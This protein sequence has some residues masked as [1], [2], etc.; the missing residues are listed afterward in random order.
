VSEDV[1]VAALV[2]PAV[3]ES[4]ARRV[5]AAGETAMKLAEAVAVLGETTLTDAGKLAE[6]AETEVVAAADRLA[7]VDILARGALLTFVHPVVRE[8]ARGQMSPARLAM[9]HTRAAIQLDERGAPLERVA[10]HLLEGAPQ[11]N[12]W[13][14]KTLVAAAAEE[15]RRGLP[16]TALSLLL[17]AREEPPPLEMRHLVNFAIAKAQAR[18]GHPDAVNTARQVLASAPSPSEQAEAALH[19]ARTLGTSGDLWS[20]LDLLHANRDDLGIDPD[21][22]LQ[23]EAELLGVARL[24]AATRDGALRRL[25]ELS[26]RAFP[27]RPATRVLLANLAL[28]ALE[29]SEPPDRVVD[30]AQMALAEGSIVGDMSFQLVY[31]LEALTWTDH[32]DD[33][34]R[35]CDVAAT[36]ARSSGALKQAVLAAH[37]RSVVNL[38]RG[39]VPDAEAD[40]RFAYDLTIGTAPSWRTPFARAGLADVLVVKGQISEATHVL[41]VPEA[42]EEAHDNPFY[43]ESRGRL[44]LARG[45]ARAAVSDF[46][47]CGSVLSRRGGVDAPA[48]FPWRSQAAI[49]L[50]RC[51]ERV[52]AREMASDEL[53]LAERS[54]I[55]GVVAE[56]LIAL[57]MIEDGE[58][59]M[60]RLR[61]ALEIL[62][63]SPRIL[64]RIRA[65][66]SLGAMLRRNGQVREARDHLLGAMNLAHHHAA[67]GLEDD[68]RRE[69][70]VAGGRPRRPATT[71]LAALTPSELRVAQL[72]AQGLSN[73]QIAHYLY[74]APRT[75]TTHL[76][77]IYQKIGVT[78]RSELSAI[79]ADQDTAASSRAASASS[80][81][82]TQPTAR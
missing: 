11:G 52:Q 64:T 73:R 19:L 26:S 17:R 27:P 34:A 81:A 74:V 79:V 16:E 28:T 65:M 3:A 55:P 18:T 78:D 48:S 44:H 6:L 1:S 60:A 57:A 46:L 23:L 58:S 10:S 36:V 67:D 71:G 33:A 59:G 63:H 80:A 24:R 56:P 77:H 30:L 13:I 51:G 69:L 50:L 76:T 66:T 38:R 82:P 7:A 2:P 4:V 53:S 20:A 68:A 31:A 21:L 54:N 8:A 39:A 35:W 25:D 62:G 45:D 5:T 41:G 37:W 61:M 70:V 40:A 22:S 14:A 47:D 12:E 42:E 72:V 32:L 29:R 15:E 43:L 9:I 49:A 75:V